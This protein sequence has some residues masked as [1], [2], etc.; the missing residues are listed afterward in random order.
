MTIEDYLKGMIGYP[1][2][3]ESISAVEINRG[4]TAGSDVSV[5]TER[6]RDL[7]IADLLMV[8][9]Q[10]P[11]TTGTEDAMGDWKHKT[12]GLAVTNSSALIKRA[13]AI[14]SKYDESTDGLFIKDKTHL[15]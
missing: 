10:T 11:S 4:I 5:V 3:D 12:S 1:V 7:A 6:Q 15:W 14:Y 9:C 8:V 13:N 2:S